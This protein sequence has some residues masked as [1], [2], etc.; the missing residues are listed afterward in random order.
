[1][2]WLLVKVRIRMG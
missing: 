1:M 2:G